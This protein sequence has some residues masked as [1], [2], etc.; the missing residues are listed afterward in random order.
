MTGTQES[1]YSS[2][3]SGYGAP[4]STF[5]CFT[6]KSWRRLRTTGAGCCSNAFCKVLI[7]AMLRVFA[8]ARAAANPKRQQCNGLTSNEY[9]RVMNKLSP[10]QFSGLGKANLPWRATLVSEL[11]GYKDT[12]QPQAEPPCAFRCQKR[13]IFHT[14]EQ[15]RRTS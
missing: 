3:V 9:A 7:K 15:K 11:P 1:W 4:F 2:A 14:M 13:Q 12:E 5:A 8:L 6:R 10:I